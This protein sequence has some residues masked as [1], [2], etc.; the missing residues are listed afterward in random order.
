MQFFSD[1][2]NSTLPNPRIT[3]SMSQ[4]KL[5]PICN[6]PI[7]IRHKLH[8]YCFHSMPNIFAYSFQRSRIIVVV[9]VRPTSS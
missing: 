6:F 2:I 9:V 7:D 4:I 3:N 1:M 8:I 5:C